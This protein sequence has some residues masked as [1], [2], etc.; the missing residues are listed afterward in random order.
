MLYA[1]I[2]AFWYTIF[3][4]NYY[5]SSRNLSL[6]TSIYDNLICSLVKCAPHHVDY[7]YHNI[8]DGYDDYDDYNNTNLSRQRR[9]TEEDTQTITSNQVGYF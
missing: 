6:L 4:L 7:E 9:M 1:S 8:D 3:F 5:L 2:K